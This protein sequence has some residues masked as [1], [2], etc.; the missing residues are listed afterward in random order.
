MLYAPPPRKR[1]GIQAVAFGAVE[2]SYVIV[3]KDG[4]TSRARVHWGVDTMIDA[5]YPLGVTDITLSPDS[6]AAFC[7]F[8]DGSW[9]TSGTSQSLNWKLNEI[10]RQGG[11]V[12]RITFGANDSWIIRYVPYI[13]VSSGDDT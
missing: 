7:R 12:Q 2:G 3:W 8:T 5:K 10:E 1:G 9:A 4:S 13:D 6:S 11:N